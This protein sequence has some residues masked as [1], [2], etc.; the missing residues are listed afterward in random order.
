MVAQH[1]YPVQQQGVTLRRPVDYITAPSCQG[2][3]S[4]WP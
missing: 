1:R 4:F 2:T 3:N